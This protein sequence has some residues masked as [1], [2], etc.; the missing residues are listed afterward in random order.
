[1][2]LFNADAAMFLKKKVK[3]NLPPKHKKL[4]SKVAH[5]PPSPIV[6]ALCN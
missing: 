4:P 5:N 1:M 6:F 3:K 2:Q